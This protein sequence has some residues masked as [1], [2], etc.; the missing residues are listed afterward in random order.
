M[1]AST[2][3]KNE[4][5]VRKGPKNHEVKILPQFIKPLV[6]GKKSFEIRYNDRD[7]QVGDKLVLNGWDKEKG[8]YT[9]QVIDCII[10]YVLWGGQ[11]GIEPRYVGL[12]L[13]VL[14]ANF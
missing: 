11:Y 4:P 12:G 14:G 9:G 6:S 3:T 10:T 1:I 8:E 5:E 13:K 2:R 7:Y